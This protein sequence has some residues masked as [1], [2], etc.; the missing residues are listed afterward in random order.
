MAR[1]AD[2]E[3]EWWM[4]R[5]GGPEIV[6]VLVMPAIWLVPADRATLSISHSKPHRTPRVA[7]SPAASTT[8]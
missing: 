7:S 4:F 2:Q 3:G 5:S 1:Q 6:V 8:S